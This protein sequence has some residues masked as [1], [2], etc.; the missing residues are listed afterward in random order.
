MHCNICSR[1]PNAKLSFHCVSCARLSLYEPRIKSAA[2][3]LE[4]ESLGRQID[5]VVHPGETTQH[6]KGKDAD[7]VDNRWDVGLAASRAEECVERT[8]ESKSCSSILRKEIELGRAEISRRKAILS[9]RRSDFASA[10]HDLV[11]RRR[12]A[13]ESVEKSIQRTSYRW[14]QQHQ[15]IT[16]SRVF[17][18]REA[19]KLYGLRQRRRKKGGVIK[20]DF[21]IGGV[22]IIDL[23]DLNNA[24]PSQITTS[25]NHIAHLLTLTSHYL[26]LQLPAQIT[27]PHRDYPLP[28]IFSPSSSYF[29]KE[30]PFPGSTP[31]HSSSTSLSASRSK[32]YRS[33]PRPRPLYLDKPLPVLSKEDQMTYSLFIE[34]ITL[35]A[36][37]IAWVC[38]SQGLNIG[39]TSWEDICPL[40]RNLWQLLIATPSQPSMPARPSNKDATAKLSPRKGSG[41]TPAEP[42]DYKP[43]PTLGH[44]SHGS[45]HSFL[46]GAEGSEYMRSWKLQGPMKIV[47]HL[48]SALLGEMAGAEWEMLD[49]RE[50]DDDRERRDDEAVLVGGRRSNGGFD[51]GK[52]V[53]STPTKKE[54]APTEDDASAD[55]PDGSKGKTGTSGWMK[56]KPRQASSGTDLEGA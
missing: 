23:R 8:Q 56:L 54:T 15:K 20:D 21:T 49:E 16:E 28:T 26:A 41:T 38:R 34:G 14:D 29:P 3:L 32:E 10:N 37:D 36:W 46:G 22:G 51:D 13:R 18:C 53:P 47:D 9:Q 31:S 7:S 35:L 1:G 19:A 40:G 25:I 17:L 43:H 24:T 42:V 50:W 6:S 33:L 11:P 44:Y 48:K 2:T 30:V 39:S 4:K 55:V 5:E 12:V 27:L 52:S 45:A